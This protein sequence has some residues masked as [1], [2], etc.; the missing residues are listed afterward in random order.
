MNKL[1]FN[2][3]KLKGV[4]YKIKKITFKNLFLDETIEEYILDKLTSITEFLY[5]RKK[6]REIQWRWSNMY[7]SGGFRV[8]VCVVCSVWN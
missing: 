5:Y 2:I 4:N 3:Y 6:N 1:I 7:M 8:T